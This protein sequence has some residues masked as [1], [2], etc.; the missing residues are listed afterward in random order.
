MKSISPK[1]RRVQ[2]VAA[3]HNL[4]GDDMEII[5]IRH[6]GQDFISTPDAVLLVRGMYY[7]YVLLRR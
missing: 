1:Y 3:A 7:V 2:Q 4:K 6:Y 5:K